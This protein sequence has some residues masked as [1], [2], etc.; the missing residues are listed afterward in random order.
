MMKAINEDIRI[1]KTERKRIFNSKICAGG[2][3]IRSYKQRN[4]ETIDNIHKP[5]REIEKKIREFEL[6]KSKYYNV[7]V[8]GINKELFGFVKQY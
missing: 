6:I 8:K 2:K 1:L 5:I 4:K 7:E 3:D